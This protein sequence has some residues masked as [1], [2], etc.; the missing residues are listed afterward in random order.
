MRQNVANVNPLSVEVNYSDQTVLVSCAVE[1][2]EFTNLIR[3]SEKL[4]PIRKIFPSRGFDRL[5]PMPQ[6]RLRI[7]MLL[8]ELLQ[9]PP[10]N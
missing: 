4:P 2:N 10:G 1:H 7:R 6:R 3:A 8:P 9:R 5:N